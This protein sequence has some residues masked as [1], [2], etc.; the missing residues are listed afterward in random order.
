MKQ[1]LLIVSGLILFFGFF[2][3]CSLLED[4]NQPEYQDQPA[5]QTRRPFK[6]EELALHDGYPVHVDKYVTGVV[7]CAAL[8]GKTVE[9][10]TSLLMTFGD[11][12]DERAP[13]VDAPRSFAML[14]IVSAETDNLD[15]GE[16]LAHLATVLI[17]EYESMS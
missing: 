13:H 11:I 14:A 16:L 15:C 1:K 4:Q 9:E 10:M 17:E 7:G 2:F 5:V 8:C 12:M 6:P 3:L